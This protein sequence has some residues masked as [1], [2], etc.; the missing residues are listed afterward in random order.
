MNVDVKAEET[1]VDPER[2]EWIQQVHP[3]LDATNAQFWENIQMRSVPA[4]LFTYYIEDEM[5]YDRVL[6]HQEASKPAAIRQ[7]TRAAA[8]AKIRRV[9]EK[10]G[11]WKEE[12]HA[13]NPTGHWKHEGPLHVV[14]PV[15][16]VRNASSRGEAY[17]L[18][19]EWKK[20]LEEM[21]E[22]LEREHNA[23]RPYQQF[24][25]LVDAWSARLVDMDRARNIDPDC[26]PDYYVRLKSMAYRF[27]R[28]GWEAYG[29]WWAKWEK[30]PGYSWMHEHDL[31]EVTDRAGSVLQSIE[32]PELEMRDSTGS[33]RA[34]E[35]G[36]D[37]SM[38]DAPSSERRLSPGQH[39]LPSN[40]AESVD[41]DREYTPPEDSQ[42]EASPASQSIPETGPGGRGNVTRYHLRP[43]GSPLIYFTPP[44]IRKNTAPK[45]SS[46]LRKGKVKV[47]TTGSQNDV[48]VQP[49]VAPLSAILEVFTPVINAGPTPAGEEIPTTNGQEAPIA[50][51]PETPT[52]AFQGAPVQGTPAAASTQRTPM[53]IF[54]QGVR[55]VLLEDMTQEQIE[56]NNILATSQPSEALTSAAR[57][58]LGYPGDPLAAPRQV[59]PTST[60]SEVLFAPTASPLPRVVTPHRDSSVP[61][62][63][64]RQSQQIAT[65][66]ETR[67]I[68]P[69]TRK[70]ARRAESADRV[71]EKQPRG[72][73]IDR[74]NNGK[75]KAMNKTDGKRQK[76]SDDS[77]IAMH[78]DLKLQAR[79]ESRARV[80]QRLN[81]MKPT[82]REK[83][84]QDY[85]ART[86]RRLRREEQQR[87]IEA[88]RTTVTKTRTGAAAA[89]PKKPEEEKEE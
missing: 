20:K 71:V 85:R 86:Q 1:P 83:H 60:T 33:D 54:T 19:D 28:E 64:E 63:D 29:I 34:S 66:I 53:F 76:I 89:E 72:N 56:Q 42:P 16:E 30:M 13:K 23:S 8:A 38:R 81:R 45:N 73:V 62:A 43:G 44:R 5:Y 25:A 80:E 21:N 46:P 35:R 48:L 40:R 55:P 84:A 18:G 59:S 79:E 88:L 15:T 12:W 11:I 67:Y 49:P 57:L 7:R 10:A 4:K 50:I 52:P 26:H 74:R 36:S 9:W 39:S 82:A 2:V 61:V 27:V 37:T 77:A 41:M 3:F 17:A 68:G 47:E 51:I 24:V 6:K 75:A 65:A 87:A 32:G 70:R 69:M 78:N 22:A 58:V 31:S 14:N